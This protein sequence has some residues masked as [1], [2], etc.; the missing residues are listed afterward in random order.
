MSIAYPVKLFT[1]DRAKDVPAGVGGRHCLV[2]DFGYVLPDFSDI[3]NPTVGHMIAKA[4]NAAHDAGIR[5]AERRI[6][7]ALGLNRKD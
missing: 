4:I 5:A 6:A 1:C 3:E 2:D 7:D